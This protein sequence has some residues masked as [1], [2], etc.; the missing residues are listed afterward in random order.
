MA[1]KQTTNES[2][3]RRMAKKVGLRLQKS[4]RRNRAAED[5]GKYRISHPVQDLLGLLDHVM[6]LD[7]VERWLKRVEINGS[8]SG[9]KT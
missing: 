1:E 6:S 7:Q 2:A 9:G 5:Y 3:V 4:R 8:A